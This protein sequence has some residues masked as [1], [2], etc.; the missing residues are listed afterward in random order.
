LR[1]SHALE[2]GVFP[3]LQEASSPDV[4]ILDVKKNGVRI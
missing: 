3:H 4:L 2:R 1:S